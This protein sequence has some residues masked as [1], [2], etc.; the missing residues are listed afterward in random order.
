VYN[1]DN[2]EDLPR[3]LSEAKDEIRKMLLEAWKLPEAERKK[4][5]HRL[6]LRWHP[7]KNPKSYDLCNEAF[8]F[9][10][11]QVIL[12]KDPIQN[13][14]ESLK[15]PFQ[16]LCLRLALAAFRKCSHSNNTSRL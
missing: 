8:K 7:D 12:C 3:T 15:N 10:K 4:V 16:V 14:F 1:E 13:L 5:I 11:N 9:L 2:K 6:Y